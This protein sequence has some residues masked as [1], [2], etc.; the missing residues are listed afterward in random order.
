M[1][2]RV[3]DVKMPSKRPWSSAWSCKAATFAVALI[4]LVRIGES[5]PAKTEAPASTARPAPPEPPLVLVLGRETLTLAPSDRVYSADLRGELPEDWRVESG[6]WTTSSKG[7][8]GMSETEGAAALWC[9]QSFPFDVVVRAFG[10]I[11]APARNDLNVYFSG[12]G[13]LADEAGAKPRDH[14]CYIAGL[15]GWWTSRHGLERH[16][17]SWSATMPA[18]RL[19]QRGM[20]EIVAGRRGG[21][22]FLFLDGE[23]IMT[24]T[25]PSPID[26]KKHDRIGLATW[27]STVRFRNVEVYRTPAP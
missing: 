23:E 26:S 5:A 3:I 2:E 15:H 12:T 9:T 27:H 11:V 14:A 20:R 1:I 16:P 25:D 22:I 4:V 21:T 7:I 24:V 17:S 10:E 19:G 13:R 8:V 6:T 18:G